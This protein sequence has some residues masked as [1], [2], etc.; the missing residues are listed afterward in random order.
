MRLAQH[1]AWTHDLEPIVRQ[2]MKDFPRLEHVEKAD[3]QSSHYLP[4]FSIMRDWSVR[5]SDALILRDAPVLV[6]Y[7]LQELAASL[8]F[9]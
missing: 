8:P 9:H 1:S 7:M 3:F 4:Q 6:E 5:Y 2:L